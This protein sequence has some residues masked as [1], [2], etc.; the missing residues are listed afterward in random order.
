MGTL[1]KEMK[2]AGFQLSVEEQLKI[3]DELYML[4]KKL[5]RSMCKKCGE[6]IKF[7]PSEDSKLLPHDLDGTP[8]WQSCAH[9][10]FAQKKASLDIMKKLSVLF[11]MKYGI[12]LEK[13]A[14]LS[15]R[16]A[17]IVHAVLERIFKG[18]EE[19]QVPP[20]TIEDDKKVPGDIPFD[21]EP[22]DSIGD[23]DEERAPSEESVAE[24][25]H[26]IDPEHRPDKADVQK[27][28][29]GMIQQKETPA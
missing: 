6:E 28:I 25:E 1:K 27:A 17:Q 15:Q 4:K 2:K 23:P 10:G 18:E 8:H 12:N 7:V 19:E 14:G 13:E 20:L 16:E 11:I 9:S 3:K 5:K 21:P 22:C 29:E 24:I 26:E